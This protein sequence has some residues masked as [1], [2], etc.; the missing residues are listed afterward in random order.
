MKVIIAGDRNTTSMDILVDALREA[1]QKGILIS[2]VVSGCCRGVDKMGELWA[3]INGCKITRFPA[4]WAT[5][6]RASG[7]LRNQTMADYADA[8]V[9]IVTP[10][11]KGTR[12]MIVRAQAA[13]LKVHVKTIQASNLP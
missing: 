8:L 10:L 1:T 4:D 9:A 11:S 5:Y 3:T 7:M 6:G 13:G 12:D 2:E